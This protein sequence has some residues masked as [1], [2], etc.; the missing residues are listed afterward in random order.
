MPQ[1]MDARC[2]TRAPSQRPRAAPA[3]RRRARLLARR[4]PEPRS[5]GAVRW[6]LRADD[7]PG[8]GA[9]M[10]SAFVTGG[11]G[12]IGGALVGRLVG[13]GWAV[14]AL[15]RSERSDERLRAVGAEPVRGD[16]AD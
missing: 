4:R 7:G 5:R 3:P 14:R 1:S 16:L 8:D 9:A 11:S 10:T 15:S 6:R 12:F 2:L 13:E